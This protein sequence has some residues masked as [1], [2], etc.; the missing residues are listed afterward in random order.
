MFRALVVPAMICMVAQAQ[1]HPDLQPTAKGWV[2][3]GANGDGANETTVFM[4]L[5]TLT[6]RS[7]YVEVVVRIYP[8]A[9][10]NHVLVQKWAYKDNGDSFRTVSTGLYNR[11]TAEFLGSEYGSAWQPV[12]PDSI[13]ESGAK[14]IRTFIDLIEKDAK[15]T[16]T[17][18]TMKL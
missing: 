1:V 10:R 7:G 2:K 11:T 9:A 4:N 14:A 6:P 16:K 18:E 17:S 12:I 13:A 5:L 8:P 3:I 15:K